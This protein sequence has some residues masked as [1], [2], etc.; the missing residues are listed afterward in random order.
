MPWQWGFHATQTQ[1]FQQ[2]AGAAPPSPSQMSMR[3]EVDPLEHSIIY[4]PSGHA[5]LMKIADPSMTVVLPENPSRDY[6][7]QKSRMTGI[8]AVSSISL[9]TVS[10]VAHLKSRFFVSTGAQ[11][12]M[13]QNNHQTQYQILKLISQPVKCSQGCATL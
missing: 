6:E 9:G 8:E 1:V 10:S 7:I 3:S 4:L 5:V 12:N 11:C 13:N 2:P